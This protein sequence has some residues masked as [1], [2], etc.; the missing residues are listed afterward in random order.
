MTI[1]SQYTEGNHYNA[2]NGDL[3][4]GNA[5]FLSRV[6]VSLLMKET[7]QEVALKFEDEV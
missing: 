2:V 4:F 3:H 7:H 1:I 6:V 5:I